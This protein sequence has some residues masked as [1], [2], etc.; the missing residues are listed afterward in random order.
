MWRNSKKLI[1]LS[2]IHSK[3]SN[4][5]I[6]GFAKYLTPANYFRK[7]TDLQNVH[8]LAAVVSA[9]TAESDKLQRTYDD[10]TDKDYRAKNI[11]QDYIRANEKKL[12]TLLPKLVRDII[13]EENLSFE[14]MSGVL[15]AA[16][17]RRLVTPEYFDKHFKAGILEKIEY[18][19]LQGLADLTTALLDAGYDKNSEVFEKVSE[20]LAEKT[21][22]GVCVNLRT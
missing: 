3:D 13:H 1:P 18:A 7:S 11:Y 10:L 17:R 20:R 4:Y 8:K 2:K 5:I 22:V 16:S 21:K 15:Y 19:S 9:L 6:A 14:T 12:D